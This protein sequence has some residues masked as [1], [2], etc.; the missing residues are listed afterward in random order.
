VE[1]YLRGLGEME[2]FTKSLSIPKPLG[3]GNAVE[4]NKALGDELN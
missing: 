4:V 1:V 3:G 2:G